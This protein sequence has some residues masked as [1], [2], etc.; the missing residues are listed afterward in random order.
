MSEPT[1]SLLDRLGPAVL[2][3]E[4]Y[5]KNN[6][7]IP[8]TVAV[9]EDILFKAELI[10]VHSPGLTSV[11]TATLDNLSKETR[12]LWII[13][14]EGTLYIIIES[15]PNPIAERKC[16]CHS[17]MTGGGAALQGGELWFLNPDSIV[18]NFRSGRYG[19]ETIEHEDAVIEYWEL[20]GFKVELE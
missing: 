11:F 7:N 13:D 19:A 3:F 4:R 20:R 2:P 1:R 5:N 10:P 16:V 15:T 9:G 8:K 12:Y 14:T 6:P 18:L 17:N